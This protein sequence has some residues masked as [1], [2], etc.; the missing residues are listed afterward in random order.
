[1]SRK[2][3][4]RY[5]KS[6]NGMRDMV[7][8]PVCPA[9]VWDA[10]DAGARRAQVLRRNSEYLDGLQNNQ[11]GH[12]HCFY[13]GPD[14]ENGGRHR[15]KVVIDHENSEIDKNTRFL[16]PDE[17]AKFAKYDNVYL[18][19]QPPIIPKRRRRSVTPPY[20]RKRSI[21]PASSSSSS[22]SENLQPD[23]PNNQCEGPIGKKE[24]GLN[25]ITEH[26]RLLI[27]PQAPAFALSTKKWM[28]VSLGHVSRIERSDDS[29]KNLQLDPSAAQIIKA[30]SMQ[31]DQSGDS[32]GADFI[33]GKG[34]G[35]VILLHGPPGV[36]KTYTVEGISEWLRR[37]LLSLTVAD[38]GITEDTVEQELMKWF[39]LAEAWNAVLLVDEAD[40]FLE[41]RKN[42]DLSRN[43]LVT[44]FLRR[45]E[46]FRGLLFLTTNRVGQIDDAFVS[47]VHMAIGY[48]KLSPEFR[49]NI[50]EGFFRKLE[51]ERAGKV[52][53]GRSAKKFVLTSEWVEEIELN[54]RE[55]RNVLQ[56][57]IALAE[58]ESIEAA[59]ASGERGTASASPQVVVVEEDHFRRVLKMSEKFH[60]YVTAIRREDES[61]RAKV[62]GDRDD[63]AKVGAADG[64]SK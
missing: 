22:S 57:A 14:I 21:S 32:W 38:I 27:W 11:K 13:D 30:L 54:G 33:E 29:I 51:R 56:T 59:G 8:L 55:T 9:S 31:Q 39:D 25:E 24:L 53:V 7:S 62:R 3:R 35:Q 36:G 2:R 26:Q 1:M 28:T 16:S 12:M 4:R 45:M 47:R 60:D 17:H 20:R 40:I 43:G 18:R 50:W 52:L 46:Y 6:F 10:L 23:Y 15:G 5:I 48:K 41:Q 49:R 63:D 44:A 42:R 64:R 37:P 34:A 58:F 19:D 61:Q